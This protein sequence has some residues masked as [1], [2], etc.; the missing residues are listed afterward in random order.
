MLD[1]QG[2]E[3]QQDE[4]E[5]LQH[6]NTGGV[7]LFSRNYSDVNQL[8]E[9]T[10][11]I[12]EI[13][14]PDLLIAVDHEGG[15]VQRFKKGFTR[16]PPCGRY[17]ELYEKNQSESLE[18][19]EMAGWLIASELLSVGIDFS[20]APVLDLDN[21]KSSVIADRAFHKD[22]DVVSQLARAFVKGLNSAGM[23]AVGKHFPG[24]GAVIED[25]HETLPVDNRS[26]EDIL[27]QDLV[28]FER[29]I[30]SGISGIM[31][32]HVV[33]PQVDDMP[34][35]YSSIWIQKILRGQMGFHGAIFSDDISMGAASVAG[36]PLARA[37][38]ALSAGCDMILICNDRQ[39]AAD[40]LDNLELDSRPDTKVRMMRMY[41]KP[42]VTMLSQLK[43]NPRWNEAV[44]RIASLDITPELDLDDD[45]VPT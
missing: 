3:L 44:T 8:T 29:L 12:H 4:L 20:F 24:H 23:A 41:G 22:S 2:T 14:H 32:A 9:L 18:Y 28:P 42:S 27:M 45:E 26:F 1:L 43:D 34:A 16:M 19:T 37:Q 35:G 11:Q 30:N 36:E 21:G 17:G 40:I 31:P 15:R 6:P 7:I 13:K 33:F 38:A 39:A 10:R 5:M 25:S